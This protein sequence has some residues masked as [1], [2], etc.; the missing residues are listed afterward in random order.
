M[1]F[2]DKQ[3]YRQL[4]RRFVTGGTMPLDFVQAA[5]RP[6]L[7]EGKA[8]LDLCAGG[9]EMTRALVQAGAAR[10]VMVDSEE[11]M[12]DDDLHFKLP[13][14]STVIAHVRPALEAMRKHGAF[15]DGAF[16][17]QGVNYWLDPDAVFKLALVLRP[18]APFVFNTFADCPPK[19]PHLKTYTLGE[20]HYVEVSWY[21]YGQVKHVQC[22]TG[23]E[24]HVT[25]FSYFS[26]ANLHDLFDKEYELTIQQKGRTL[27]CVATR[28]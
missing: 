2:P 4:Y 27:L 19:M 18:G 15:F 21:E 3:T 7:L 6:R 11:R 12:L 13:Q 26:K 17:R 8:V 9:G 28:R 10:V 5:G 1:N 22:C 23:C 14:V 25:A 20:D 16:C 24:P